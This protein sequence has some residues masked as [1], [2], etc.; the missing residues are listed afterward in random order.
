LF[1]L[2]S[3]AVVDKVRDVF[4]DGEEQPQLLFTNLSTEQEE[5]LRAVFA[6]EHGEDAESTPRAR[7]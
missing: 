1:L 2:T 7:S 3:E 6:E 5:A 4:A